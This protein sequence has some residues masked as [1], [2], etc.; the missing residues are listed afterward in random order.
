MPPQHSNELRLKDEQHRNEVKEQQFVGSQQL[1]DASSPEST[2]PKDFLSP[3]VSSDKSDRD[4]TSSDGRDSNDDTDASD[5]S[6]ASDISDDNDFD[7]D[8][9]DNGETDD[10]DHAEDDET[11][12]L[13]PATEAFAA[14]ID[15]GC[16]AEDACLV[17]LEVICTLLREGGVPHAALEAL[18]ERARKAFRHALIEGAGPLEAWQLVGD[19]AESGDLF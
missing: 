16:G 9:D 11:A 17:G 6:D 4:S 15:R 5:A 14:A 18:Q 19:S 7:D 1:D 3:D 12:T 2:L 8:S 10:V 13:D